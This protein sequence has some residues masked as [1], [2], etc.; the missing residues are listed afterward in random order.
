MKKTVF[1]L[2]VL[3]QL[4]VFLG[5]IYEKNNIVKNGREYRFRITYYDP[6]DFMRGNYLRISLEQREIETK[7][8]EKYNREKGY[9]IIN[10]KDSLGEIVEFT[11]ENPKEGDYIKGEITSTYNGKQW[12]KN[13]FERYYVEE[14]MAKEMEEKLRAS[15]EAYLRVK[16]YKG[17]YVIESIEI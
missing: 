10:E 5:M 6:Y 4:G 12:I 9:F 7:D 2:M 13:P 16:I 15:N 17:K 3:L 8:D 11:R 14:K 1:I